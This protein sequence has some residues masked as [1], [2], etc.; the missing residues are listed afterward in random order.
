MGPENYKEFCIDASDD[1]ISED[2]STPGNR[3]IGDLDMRDSILVVDDEDAVRQVLRRKLEQCGYDICEAAD[4]VEAINALQTIPFDLV[5]TDVI[6][7][8][9]DGIQTLDF[10]RKKCSKTP[11]IIISAPS[12]Q[13]YLESALGLGASRA[14]YKPVQLEEL[15]KAVKQLLAKAE[16]P[17]D[18]V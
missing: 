17:R 6:M 15:A 5:I 9:K 4:G 1:A 7:P 3:R 2:A 18:C 11:V 14:F 8:E 12:N 10:I 16:S 13:L